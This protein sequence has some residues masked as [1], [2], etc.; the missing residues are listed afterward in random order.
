MSALTVVLLGIL[1]ISA[2]KKL[3]SL[4]LSVEISVNFYSQ[5]VFRNTFLQLLVHLPRLSFTEL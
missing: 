5:E 1:K 2:I 4:M 3:F